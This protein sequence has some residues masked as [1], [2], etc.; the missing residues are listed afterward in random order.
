MIICH[1]N[2][3]K[4]FRGGERQ[5]ELLVRTLSEKGLK[6]HL[7]VLK[8]SP[9]SIR[10]KNLAALEISEINKPYLIH[11]GACKNCD[12]LHAHEAKA[13]HFA[14]FVNLLLNRPYIITR[15]IPNPPKHNFFTHKVYKNAFRIAALSSAIKD[16]MTTYEKNLNIDIIPSMTSHLPVSSDKIKALRNQYAGKF[17]VGHIGALSN[18]HKGQQYII[19]TASILQKSHPDIHFLLLGQGKDE[20]WLKQLAAGLQNVTFV[21]FVDNV[22][23]YLELFDLFIFPSLEEGLGSILLDAMEFG[24][25]II[26]TAVDGIPDIIKHNK[27]GLLIEPRNTNLLKDALI[28]LHN[29]AR[30]RSQLGQ[31]GKAMARNYDPEIIA[32]KYLDLYSSL[33]Q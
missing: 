17:I 16:T 18:H 33:V 13:S 29:D 3:A 19:E 23:D 15:R 27:N 30:L 6:Q 12:L 7:V 31:N 9:L 4:G 26:A 1:I 8:N 21:G 5:T 10:L 24:K 25:P 14:F 22:G 11:F 2:L 32:Q 28:M 20:Q